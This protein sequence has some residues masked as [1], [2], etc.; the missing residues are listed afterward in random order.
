MSTISFRLAD[1]TFT[2]IPAEVR[3]NGEQFISKKVLGKFKIDSG[4][5]ICCPDS[6]GY[7]VNAIGGNLLLSKDRKDLDVGPHSILDSFFIL[8]NHTHPSS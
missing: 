1:G 7:I 4:H 2:P 6:A 5:V 8:P 3:E